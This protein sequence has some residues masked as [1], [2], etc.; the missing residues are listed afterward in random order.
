M[1][2]KETNVILIHAKMTACVC[3]SVVKD[4][5]VCVNQCILVKTVP[6]TIVRYITN[7]FFF[8]KYIRKYKYFQS[9]FFSVPNARN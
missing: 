6:F 4:T 5:F 2:K 8:S 7:N 3:R 9:I 1:Q